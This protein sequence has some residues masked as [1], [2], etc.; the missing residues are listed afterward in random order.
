[1]SKRT[2]EELEK[3]L[4]TMKETESKTE[5]KKNELT[6]LALGIFPGENGEWMVARIQYNPYTGKV[7]DIEKVD[8]GP[9]KA[10]AAEKFKLIA[11][12]E[13]VIV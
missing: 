4:T 12:K 11:I 9:G 10:F 8:A 7:G 5:E 6:Y 3:D 2:K 1:M 13:R